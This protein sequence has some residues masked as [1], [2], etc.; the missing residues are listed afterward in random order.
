M[1]LGLD[2]GTSCVKAILIN[3]SGQFVASS[4]SA[5]SI[6]HPYPLWA[7]QQPE[8][9]IH[10]TEDCI[11]Q[12]DQHHATELQAVQ[13]MGLAGQMHGAVCLDA[14][15][16]V[17]RPAILWNDGRSHIECRDLMAKEPAFIQLGGNQV[18]PGFTA[19]KLL[20]LKRHEPDLFRQIHQVLL[21]KDFV[22]YVITGDYAT[23]LSDASGTL[24]LDVANRC[25]S[26]RLL[27]ASGLD[28]SQVPPVYEGNEVI[29]TVRADW[30]Q[31]VGLASNC[32]VVAGASDNAGA[33][34]AAEAINNGQGL[35]SLGTSGV[36]FVANDRFL[37][38]PDTGVH[39]FCHALPQRWHQMGVILSAAHSLSWWAKI[40]GNLDEASLVSEAQGVDIKN[41][42]PIFLPY[43]NGERT[44]HN[45]PFAQGCFIGMNAATTRAML[46]QSILES[47]AF[48]FMDCQQALMQADAHIERLTVTGGGAHSSYWLQLI[49]SIL[50]RPLERSSLAQQ[51]PALGAAQLARMADGHHDLDTTTKPEPAIEPNAEWHPYLMDRYQRFQISYQQLSSQFTGEKS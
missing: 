16:A 24:W 26:E 6:S 27:N 11:Q 2:I 10:A 18:M 14:N 49:A 25:W 13:V 34:I 31:K 42:L 7:E 50:Q 29:G 9:W 19:P 30:A 39:A 12:L 41:P 51:G 47:L 36:Y 20:W 23:D 40:Q 38:A 17:L 37:P 33:A 15:G 28:I 4:K 48:C 45:N 32:R 3:D 35:L 44:P 46:T 43:L 5:L 1:Y 22:R 8:D 21:P